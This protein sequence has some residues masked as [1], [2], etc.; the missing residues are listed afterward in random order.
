MKSKQIK[1]I[2]MHM[3]KKYTNEKVLWMKKVYKLKVCEWTKDTNEIKHTN[4]K[5]M[6]IKSIRIK[7]M[8]LKKSIQIKKMYRN[9]KTI[10]IE[11]ILIKS[12]QMK[13]V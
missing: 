5:I 8:R 7:V 9:E 6:R 1:G 11:S 10:Q 13:K 3:K 2:R 12:M 4:E